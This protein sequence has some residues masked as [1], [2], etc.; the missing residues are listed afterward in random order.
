M[1]RRKIAGVIPA[2]DGL[3]GPAPRAIAFLSSLCCPIML[4]AA[5]AGR[6]DSGVMRFAMWRQ[7]LPADLLSKLS[8]QFTK[9][10]KERR[11]A[12]RISTNLTVRWNTSVL[13]HDSKVTDLSSRGC[14]IM[15][16]DRMPENKLFTVKQVPEKEA[17]LIELPLSRDEWLKLHGEVIYRIEGI[18]FAV[19]FLN[20]TLHEAQ[21]LRTFIEK[22][23]TGSLKALPFPRVRGHKQ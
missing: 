6:P 16:A 22:Q 8:D 11:G 13:S 4:K 9:T 2:P 5:R 3:S 10:M 12:K 18:G 14:F 1:L 15:L 19:R 17:I 23:E 21:A 7:K 20:L